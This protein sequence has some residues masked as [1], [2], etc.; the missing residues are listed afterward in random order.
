VSESTWNRW[1]QEN[2]TQTQRGSEKR[3]H[4]SV[5]S[6][7]ADPAS[8]GAPAS[9]VR[10]LPAARAGASASGQAVHPQVPKPLH[11]LKEGES[12]D[13]TATSGTVYRYA[14]REGWHGPEPW[15]M[16][17]GAPCGVGFSFYSFL[18]AG[19]LKHVGNHYYC[20]CPA[21]RNQSAPVDGR[22]CKHLREYL[23]EGVTGL[24]GG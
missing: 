6:N 4:A 7:T 16:H 14:P 1:V 15:S 10:N 20:T 13:F 12:V 2:A 8:D 18:L 23:G 24:Y 11:E 9:K 5:A 21:W 19:R 3:A 22:T 17:G